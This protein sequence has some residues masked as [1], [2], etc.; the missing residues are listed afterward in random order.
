[1]QKQ[2]FMK[3]VK[4]E[5]KIIINTK[6]KITFNSI[7]NILT[8]A[9][10]VYQRTASSNVEQSQDGDEQNYGWTNTSVHRSIF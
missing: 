3:K 8:F 7:P 10:G 6:L 1:M 2:L 5:T 4:W 9:Q